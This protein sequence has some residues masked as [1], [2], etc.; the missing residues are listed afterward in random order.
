M[1]NQSKYAYNVLLELASEYHDLRY[2]KNKMLYAFKS[3][4]MC[5]ILNI[6]G[7][8]LM[9]F[10]CDFIM[11]DNVINKVPVTMMMIIKDG[12]RSFIDTANMAVI[13]SDYKDMLWF[14]EDRA[15]IKKENKCCVMNYK[16]GKM[17][18]PPEYDD[19]HPFYE[20]LA[21]AKKDGKCGVIDDFGRSMIPFESDFDYSGGFS[22]GMI[23]VRK[24]N[25]FGFIDKN[26]KTVILTEY[27]VLHPFSDGFAIA[28][29]DNKQFY[30]DKTG[31]EILSPAFDSLGPFR[32]GLAAVKKDDKYGFIDKSGK[33]V[34]PLVY[35]EGGH[36]ACFFKEGFAMVKK[37]GKCGYIDKVGNIVIPFEYDYAHPICDGYAVVQ[38]GGNWGVLKIT[39]RNNC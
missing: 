5:N 12:K 10:E 11:F 13:I 16:T 32:E 34:I 31:K 26:G 22:E 8:V 9:S 23:K 35:E 2:F 28:R 3:E 24:N 39:V 18:I 30:I 15:A 20:G 36:Y 17:I 14:K 21:V 6:A 37:D 27:D 25:K 7:K 29:K 1:G 19:I 38:K 33:L 4:H